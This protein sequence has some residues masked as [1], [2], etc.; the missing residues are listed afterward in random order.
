MSKICYVRMDEVTPDQF[1]PL[2]NKQKIRTHLIKHHLFDEETTKEWMADKVEMDS[3]PKCR[4]RAV[5][6]D[7]C[8][9]GWCGIQLEEGKY[10]IAI[11]L[12]DDFWGAG[13][14]VFQKIMEW[15]REFKHQTLLIHFL[16]TRPK[17][18][19][20]QKMARSVCETELMGNKFTTYELI[21]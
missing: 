8:L 9:A 21:V 19:F 18:K 3:N 17:Y 13:K 14:R 10:E 12:D 7:S 6:V 20:L 16:N 2:L 15:A 11:V 1:L 5:I 4:V